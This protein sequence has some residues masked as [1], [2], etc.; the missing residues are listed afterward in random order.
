MINGVANKVNVAVA[1]DMSA[2]V[3]NLRESDEI[4]SF[5]VIVGI[6]DVYDA[7]T[8][9]RI[10]RGAIC[11]FDVIKIFEDDGMELYDPQVLLPV[12]GNLAETYIHHTV[13]LS[14]E[15]RGEVIMIN[16]VNLA[17]PVVQT[18]DGFIDL[19]KKKDIKIE[20]IL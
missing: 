15:R 19:A 11:P 14:D 16:P 6:A 5:S 9:K 12:L 1:Y 18:S 10:Y 2:P 3:N 17:Y 7:M 13:R 4:D 20:A 8:S